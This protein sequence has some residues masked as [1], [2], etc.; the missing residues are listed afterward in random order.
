MALPAIPAAWSANIFAN[1]NI[2]FIAAG[3]DKARM[4][5]V[6]DKI[7]GIETADYE[8]AEVDHNVGRADRAVQRR[9]GRQQHGRPV[10]QIRP[11][12]REGLPRRRLPLHRHDRRTGLG[13]DC[14]GRMGRAFA[15]KGLLLSPGV[16]QMY[17]TGEIAANICL[18][19]P[20]LDTLDIWC[21]GRAF[22]PTPRRRLSSR[23]CKPS[24]IIW[25]RTN[26]SNGRRTPISRSTFPVS[27]PMPWS[28]PGPA[29]RIPSGS[30]MILASPIARRSAAFSRAR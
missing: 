1:C 7:P 23:S 24:G 19:T 5:A 16:A 21:S 3:R 15:A 10:H 22:R 8:V 26:T 30:R 18:E 9:P 12:D 29:L 13:H 20:G 11:G 17:T 6:M 25:S 14:E 4:Q 27:T 2:P 28:P